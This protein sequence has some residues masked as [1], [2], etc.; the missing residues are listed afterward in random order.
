[1]EELFRYALYKLAKAI[2]YLELI[3]IAVCIITVVLIKLQAGWVRRRNSAIQ[4]KLSEMISDAIAQNKTE[5]EIPTSLHSFKNVITTLEAFDRKF[6]DEGWLKLKKN[7][8]DHVLLDKARSYLSGYST[9]IQRQRAARCFQLCPEAATK[10]EI[11]KLL[12]DKKF[13]IRIIGAGIAVKTPYED[14]FQ[15]VIRIMSKENAQSRFP[16]RDLVM[17]VDSE[18][19]HWLEKILQ[20][21]S[22]PAVS[23]VCLDLLSTRTTSNLFPLIIPFIYGKDR[24]CRHLAIKIL[25]NIP[26]DEAADVLCHCLKDKD[27]EIRAESLKSIDPTISRKYLPA[28]QELLNDSVWFVR[29]QAALLLK[30]VGREGVEILST[31]NPNNKPEAYEIAKYVLANPAF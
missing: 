29:L 12:H 20:T 3:I 8:F 22:D 2:L 6:T 24:N 11:Y 14:L 16:Y 28:I 4:G 5:I 31:V 19:F 13:L 25:K 7:I 27:W 9:W 17:H 21:D 26:S 18:K 1:M 30:R 15:E 23:A 10:K